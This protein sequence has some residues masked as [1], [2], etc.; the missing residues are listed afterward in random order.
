MAV[1]GQRS[2]SGWV[3]RA[4]TSPRLKIRAQGGRGFALVSGT[5]AIRAYFIA[6]AVTVAVYSAIPAARAPASGVL[7]LLSIAA[8]WFAV[9]RQ[10]SKRSRAWILIA[11]AVGLFTI[12]DVIITSL[13][14]AGQG[15]PDFP[16]L[17][18]LFFLACYVSLALGLLE[19]GRPPQALRDWLLLLDTIAL[20]VA[21]SLLAW[22]ALIRPVVVTMHLSSVGKVVAVM[23]WVGF[24][25]VFA[26]AA[27][28]VLAWRT[29]LA[30]KIVVLGAAGF[31]V[32]D[33]TYGQSL[34]AGEWRDVALVD[35]GYGLFIVLAG[36]AALISSVS[37]L[38]PEGGRAR[39]LGVRQLVV[40]A[41]A[42]LIAPTVLLIEASPGPVTTGVAIGIVAVTVAVIM[43]ARLV[44]SA[45][46][47]KRRAARDH[48]MKVA[49]RTLVEATTNAEVSASLQ[50]ALTAMLPP[51]ST[52]A[53]QVRPRAPH[54]TAAPSGVARLVVPVLRSSTAA[55]ASHDHVPL[56]ITFTAPTNEMAE[57]RPSL[58]ALSDQARAALDRIELMRRLRAD[59]RERYFRTLVLTSTDATLISRGG[60]ID[61]ATPSADVIFGRDVKGEIFDD[62]VRRSPPASPQDPRPWSDNEESVEGYLVRPDGEHVAVLVHRRDLTSDATVNGVV[63]TLRDV[64]A[65][66]RLQD[67]LAYRA[68][69]DALT[70]LSNARAFGDELRGED[71][72]GVQRRRYAGA[73]RAAI[74]VDLDDFKDVNDNYGHQVGDALLAEAA[75]RIASCLRDEDLA[76]R[77]GGDE[78]AVLLRGVPDEPAAQSIAQRIVDVLGQP[79]TVSGIALNGQA[80]VGLAY[81]SRRGDLETLIR[82]ADTA[83]YNAKAQG[84]GRW[85]QY[86]DGMINPTRHHVDARR[87]LEDALDNGKLTVHY[88]PIVELASGVPEGFEALI[89]S[90]ETQPPFAPAELIAVAEHT[91]L[92]TSVG[93][94]VLA[95]ALLDAT[96]WRGGN[97]YVS[98]NVSARQLRQ[99][100]FVAMVRSHLAA[101][102]TDPARLVL[103]ITE[104][105]LVANDDRAWSY[106]AAL[107]ED[108]VRI[109][110]DDYGTGYASLSYL[111]Q[112]VIDVVKID[113][114][115][116][117]DVASA[118]DRQLLRAVCSLCA[119][120]GLESI[121]EGVRNEQGRD[122]LIEAG[123]RYGQGFL[124]APAL[125]IDEAVRWLAQ[126]ESA[127]RQSGRSVQRNRR[128]P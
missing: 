5:L 125:P 39:Q 106:L 13:V 75:R 88:Q 71:A 123:C 102:D 105:V 56:E 42:L 36:A 112:P 119:D 26:A 35:A 110:I 127:L 74:F 10:P 115:F 20:G 111:R 49:T 83:L 16:G 79:M 90:D 124:Y 96:R 118:R 92:I 22:I 100:D 68:S 31:L 126:S 72:P 17:A 117:A 53:V 59:E 113:R 62:A 2:C 94:F 69:H 44:L 23:S 4:R 58:Q 19:L 89:R 95:R 11:V 114:S 6:C 93:E 37:L 15:P 45:Q 116:V 55:L 87:R 107:R 38:S 103:E 27:R 8:V 108:G 99:P 29:D 76:A 82:N 91:G 121:A 1:S 85:R 46:I 14:T 65:E 120:L 128:S 80:S 28:V 32:A 18:D 98:V 78:F 67:D 3:P 101:S 48:A 40:L 7:G 34:V 61:Y 52:G 73:G 109:A 122:A 63:S 41:T 66:R 21:G 9:L 54:S 60:R 43:V 12:G 30:L 47:H 97:A 77:L 57:L 51:P 84:K 81:T 50:S 25:A 33:F 104:S 24:V 86:H 70:G 64:T